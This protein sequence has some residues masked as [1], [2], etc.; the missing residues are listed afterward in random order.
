[1]HLRFL[2]VVA[3]L[4]ALL[5][6][7]AFAAGTAPAAW[8]GLVEV[9]ARG[10]DDA[11]LAPGADF[12][13]YARLLI[14]R[15]EVAFHRD[16]MRRPGERRELAGLVRDEQARRI[17]ETARTNF[18]DAFAEVFTRAGYTVVDAPGPDVLR[19]TPRLTDLYVNAPDVA[20]PGR[21]RSYTANAGEATMI[22]ELRDSETNA[23]LGRLLDRRETR[24]TVGL[25]LANSVG[26]D[27]D[28]RAL[29]RSW[30]GVCVRA[31]GSLKASSPLPA[32]LAPGQTL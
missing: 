24:E 6:V 21:A 26:T 20:A 14:D 12:R 30:A 19:V 29:F 32:T 22:L 2:P 13:P 1:M 23:L 28:F 3:L 18:A 10:L 9:E 31:L 11:H 27:A 16:W 15:T 17:L 8:D 4:L 25:Q 5:P 7:R